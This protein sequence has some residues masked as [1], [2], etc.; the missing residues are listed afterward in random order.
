MRQKKLFNTD[1]FFDKFLYPAAAALDLQDIHSFDTL[2][3]GCIIATADLMDC[4]KIYREKDKGVFIV[5]DNWVQ[6][7]EN[8]Q[9][10]G[11]WTPGRYAWELANVQVLPEPILC[12]GKHRLWEVEI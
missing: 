10:F 11:D 7:S 9:L 6:I 4:H 8:E 12:K 1:R 2:P 5:K 3:Y